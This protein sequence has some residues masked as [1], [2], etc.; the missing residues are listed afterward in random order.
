MLVA[1]YAYLGADA[2]GATTT[3]TRPPPP[4]PLLI[5]FLFGCALVLLAGG[6]CLGLVVTA[7]AT[8][9]GFHLT[10]VLARTGLSGCNPLWAAVAAALSCAVPVALLTGLGTCGGCGLVIYDGSA[11]STAARAAH[12]R[13]V[14]LGGF[15]G[16]CALATAPL[17]PL[18]APA[19]AAAAFGTGPGSWWAWLLLALCGV[20]GTLLCGAV[21]DAAAAAVLVAAALG[22]GGAAAALSALGVPR[23]LTLALE[24]GTALL[25]G[26]LQ[27]LLQRRRQRVL[28]RTLHSPGGAGTMRS[29]GKWV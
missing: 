6:R 17:A 19:A 2:A 16:G 11:H 26:A 13:A 10:L 4:P 28:E 22:A 7:A 14:R 1:G 29:K 8:V 27:L 12:R 18:L 21:S 25:G 5:L 23:P 3:T 20:A 9:L 15:L 24:A